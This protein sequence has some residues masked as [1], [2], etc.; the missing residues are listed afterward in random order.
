MHPLRFRRTDVRDV[1]KSILCNLSCPYL[2]SLSIN[3]L[4]KAYVVFLSSILV[5]VFMQ[6]DKYR[7]AYHLVCP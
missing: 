2:Y 3:V 4:I 1:F 7:A 6:E 5:F